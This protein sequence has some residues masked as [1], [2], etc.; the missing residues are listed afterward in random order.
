[1]KYIFSI[2]MLIIFTSVMAHAQ[3]EIKGETTFLSPAV[4]ETVRD[5]MGRQ[6]LGA[7]PIKNKEG[8]KDLNYPDR[9]FLPM[10]P[11][12]PLVSQT[13]VSTDSRQQSNITLAL[14]K[15]VN[16]TAASYSNA[17]ASTLYVPPDNMG[18]V[19]PTQYIL[20]INS[21]IT[22]FNKTTGVADGILNAN[23]DVFFNS[24][25]T[26]GSATGTSDPHIRYD[27]LSKKWIMDIID[28]PSTANRILIAVS[29][30]S[31]ITASTTWKFFYYQV[32]GGWCDYP[33]LGIDANAIYIGG[34]LFN[35]A[36]TS[37]IG[38]IGL[39]VQKSSILGAGPIV[40][41][42][43]TL[44]AS[45]SG[46]YTPQGVDQL[47]DPAATEGYFIGTGN[48][49]TG[50]LYLYRVT[51]PGSASPTMS[52]A[53]S[54]TVPATAAPT[55]LYS[56]GCT[57]NIDPD[58]DRLFAAMIRNGHLW[59]AHHIETTNAGV[60]SGSGTRISARWYDIINYKTGSTPAL[61]QSGTV[62]SSALTSSY[63]KNYNYPT[64]TVNGQGHALMGFD[65]TGYYSYA[66]AGYTFRLNSAT[67]GTMQAPDSNTAS[68][69][70]YT[71][72]LSGET[73]TQRWGDYSMTEVDPSDNMTFWTIQQFCDAT[74][75]YACRVTQIKAP[76]PP[77][78][79]SATPS[80]L[81]SGS[82]LTVVIKGDTT[83]G[84]GFYEPGSSFQNHLTA[85]IDGGVVVNS[86]TY[87]SPS[88]ITLNVTTTSA[89]A[90]ARTV[91]ITNPDGQ[92][93]TSATLVTYALP[94]ELTSFTAEVKR[95]NEI[96]VNWSTATEVN[97]SK[98]EV[99]RSSDNNS[100]IVLSSIKAA[101]NSNAKVNYSYTD[102]SQLSQGKY[103]YRL[104]QYDNDGAFKVFNT[105]E[106]NY[107]NIPLAFGLNQNYPNPFNPSTRISF[108]VPEKS[109]VNVTV[110]DILGNKVT[111]LV[112]E[113]K[114]PGQYD[115][116]F[117]AS[118][119][120][121]GV[122]FYK[123]QADKFEVTKKM[124]V[125]K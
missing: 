43:Y 28:L 26:G 111:T 40:C 41:T 55:T 21:R 85:A 33:T 24:V 76:A 119:L 67:L 79:T 125:I 96:Q 2:L 116:T 60:G 32:S 51:N 107:T 84:L 10:N 20:A 91:T 97:S 77:T 64:I 8:E 93:V 101:G 112:N 109:N 47:Y 75:S 99:E 12:S 57:L 15:G 5:I 68:T 69:T 4:T 80:T 110:Y 9:H 61:N 6:I 38:T 30:D 17:T 22:T 39:V 78:L 1:M 100:W 52:S 18:A 42:K 108:Q 7:N 118:H 3:Q 98:F 81:G 54:L 123:M 105:V 104:K 83:T 25:E 19:G 90:G 122:Y 74:G 86:V 44:G 114:Q 63:D 73:S 88:T 59:T 71:A 82:N 72:A 115:I 34:N 29:S 95:I 62:Y 45:S 11:N 94:V 106:V 53:I 56:K 58:D 49:T 66:N 31:I 36:G 37:F 50:V 14:T 89:T 102:I 124:T 65:Q 87:N 121:S 23:L 13:G 120:S 70:A 103:Y 16:F 92:V 35:V 27:R 117:D 46:I 48:G 113:T